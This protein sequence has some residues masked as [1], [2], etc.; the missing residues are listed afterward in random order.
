MKTKI[1]NVFNEELKTIRNNATLYSEILNDSKNL[2][3]Y[4][5]SCLEELE[6]G[7][8]DLFCEDSYNL[9]KERLDELHLE[10]THIG[11]TST[12]YL[13]PKY[14]DMYKY[15]YHGKI[16]PKKIVYLICEYSGLDTDYIEIS[17]TGMITDL[18]DIKFADGSYSTWKDYFLEEH[19][20]QSYVDDLKTYSDE[21]L[22]EINNIREGYEYID[23][24]KDNQVE[25]FKEW[26]SNF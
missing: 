4:D 9:F 21:F 19:E 17:E 12:F 20:L 15:D 6:N 11:R 7:D 26:K 1:L 5:V 13:N 3:L 22:S 10:E 25:I 8:F 24:F 18:L 23:N 2:K 16:N 14:F